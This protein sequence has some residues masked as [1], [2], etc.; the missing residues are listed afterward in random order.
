MKEKDD[1]NW[2]RYT[3]LFYKKEMITHFINKNIPIIINKFT[4]DDNNEII[5]NDDLHL[6]WKEL[7]HQIHKLKVKSIFE[8]GCGNGHHLINSQKINPN[9]IIN[10]CDYSQSQID[11]GKEYFNLNDYEFYNRLTV[12][13]IINTKDISLLGKH[14]FVYTQAVTMHLAYDRAKK[15]LFNMK[16]LSS[17]Y[18]FLIENIAAHD[19]DKLISEIFPEFERIKTDKYINNGIL[20]KRI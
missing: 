8:C 19:Y 2:E 10:G 13:D 5:F 1:F 3:E 16:E 9:L 12:T 15:F 11:L 20:L 18:I 7:Y 6:N 14:E 17:K 4:Y